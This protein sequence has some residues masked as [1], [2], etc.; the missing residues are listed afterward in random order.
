VGDRARPFASIGKG[1]AAAAR[2]PTNSN[3]TKFVDAASG[4]KPMGASADGVS[5]DIMAK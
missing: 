1:I 3:P 5:P 4:M 2:A